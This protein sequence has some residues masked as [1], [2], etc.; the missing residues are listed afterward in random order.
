MKF[1]NRLF[2]TLLFI[3]SGSLNAAILTDQPTLAVPVAG[4]VLHV[5]DVSDTTSNPA[6]TS[7]QAT[8]ANLGQLFLANTSVLVNTLSDLPAPV[9]GT[10]TLVANT[11]YSLGDDVSLG[12]NELDVSA[13]NI[14]WT[15]NNIFGPTLTYTGTGTMFT[16]VDASFNIYEASLVAATGEVFDFSDIAVPGT[17]NIQIKD[18]MVM[19]CASWGDFN[20][21][22]AVTIQNVNGLG[23]DDGLDFA[24]NAWVNISLSKIGLL[25]TSASFVGVDLGSAVSPNLEI[26]NMLM[27][28]PGGAV[29]VSGAG[30]SGNITT[31]SIGTFRDS[32]FIGGMTELS[33]ISPDDI[34]WAF[35]L[36]SGVSD[37]M[38]DAMLSLNSNVTETVI[39]VA[40]THVKIAGTWVVERTSHFTG[41]TTGTITYVAERDLTVPIDI[42]TT[43]SAV[44]GSNK[45]IEVCLALNGTVVANSCKANRVGQND[46]RSTTVFW[47]LTLVQTDFLEVFISNESDTINLIAETAISRAR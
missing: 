30:S 39:S 32:T 44:S 7:K 23:C 45:D 36:N 27:S 22:S 31:G 14:S 20:N 21:L 15:S 33:G 34:R 19:G 26:S 8:L 46:P 29:G 9:T 2:I 1:F 11:N 6:G 25:S 12:T 13:G 35:D 47:Q 40:G 10:I 16:G 37:T 4:D 17:N 28:A 41:D 38:P 3:G 18:I 42:T 43:I 5:V 24:G